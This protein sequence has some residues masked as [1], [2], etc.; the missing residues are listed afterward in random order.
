MLKGS[1][2]LA[3][4]IVLLALASSCFGASKKATFAG[5]VDSVFDAA[6]RAARLNWTV[7]AVDRKTGTL[8]FSAG[9]SLTSNG[10]DCSV[11][12]EAIEPGTVQVTLIP[13]KKAQLF[14]WDVG[15]RIADK[16]F[17]SVQ[18]EL[19]KQKTAKLP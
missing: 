13:H 5:D 10:I 1:R 15:K 11:T 9:M 4:A 19:D 12:V 17:A 8:S 3:V 18:S 7:G 14:A 6:V 2:V 16:F